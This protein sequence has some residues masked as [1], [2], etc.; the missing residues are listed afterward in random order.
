LFAGGMDNTVIPGAMR[1]AITNSSRHNKLCW[2][3][4][5]MIYAV[6]IYCISDSLLR[7]VKIHRRRYDWMVYCSYDN[8]C[9]RHDWVFCYFN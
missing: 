1:K 6:G 9:H 4:L 3:L 7:L 2:G 8:S 5:R